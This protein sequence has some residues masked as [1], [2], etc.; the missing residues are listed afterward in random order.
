MQNDALDARRTEGADELEEMCVVGFDAGGSAEGECD[1]RDSLVD[2]WIQLVSEQ[3]PIRRTD[4]RQ[5]HVSD[6][7]SVVI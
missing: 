5:Q 3:H 4:I 6:G 2:L 1:V 7:P